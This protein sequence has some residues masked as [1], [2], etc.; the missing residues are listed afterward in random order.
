MPAKQSACSSIRRR[1]SSESLRSGAAARGLQL[2]L[3]GA[4][5]DL[6]RL[7]PGPGQ[8]LLPH[9]GGAVGHDL[10]PADQLLLRQLRIRIVVEVG[11][12]PAGR[13]RHLSRRRASCPWRP[14]RP[15]RTWTRS[16]GGAVVLGGAVARGCGRPRRVGGHRPAGTPARRPGLRARRPRGDHCRRYGDRRGR[17]RRAGAGQHAG[18]SDFRRL[19]AADQPGPWIGGG[20]CIGCGAC[21]LHGCGAWCQPYCGGCRGG[22]PGCCGQAMDLP[23]GRRQVGP[24]VAARGPRIGWVFRPRAGYSTYAQRASSSIGRAADF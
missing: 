14:V 15:P 18:G 6:R 19:V 10:Q 24:I 22:G 2:A 4:D 21:Q 8:R 7:E 9:R 3:I 13:L 5:P 23:R 1:T 16:R 12:L 17:D 20:A 11:H